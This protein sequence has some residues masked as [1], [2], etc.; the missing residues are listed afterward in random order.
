MDHSNVW[1]KGRNTPPPPTSTC[2]YWGGTHTSP[3][4]NYWGVRGGHAVECF[5]HW[6][7]DSHWIYNFEIYLGMILK[8]LYKKTSMLYE[9]TPCDIGNHPPEL[10]QANS[11]S[12]NHS[13]HIRYLFFF[14]INFACQLV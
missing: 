2:N 13:I 12:R 8:P 4:S 11:Y 6:T 14:T 7:H 10:P 5:L 3:T 9:S 1:K